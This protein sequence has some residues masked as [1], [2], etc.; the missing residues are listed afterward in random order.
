MT[1]PLTFSKPGPARILVVDDHATARASVV[2]VLRR[3]GH[4]AF[5]CS[6]A[7]EALRELVSSSFDVVVTDLQM[8]GMSGLG[9]DP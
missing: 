5:A 2:D 7:A 6:S 9:V 8:P 3:C 4:E 1:T